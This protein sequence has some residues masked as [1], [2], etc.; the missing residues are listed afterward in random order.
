MVVLPRILIT[1]PVP[2]EPEPRCTD[3]PVER[4]FSRLVRLFGDD[5]ETASAASTVE[6]ALPTSRWRRSPVAVTTTSSSATA[7][8]ESWK[9]SVAVSPPCTVTVLELGR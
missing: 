5:W 3:T 2:T 7:E 6:M 1:S 4:P 8:T 9:F